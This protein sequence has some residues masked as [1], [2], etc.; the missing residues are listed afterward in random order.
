MFDTISVSVL[1]TLKL[2]ACFGKNWSGVV[3]VIDGK[4]HVIELIAPV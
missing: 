4:A 3:C 2:I 1:N